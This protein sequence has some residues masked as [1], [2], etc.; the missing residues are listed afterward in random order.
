[1]SFTPRFPPWSDGSSKQRFIW[2]PSGDQI[3]SR[4]P[5]EWMR[6]GVAL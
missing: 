5:D 2:L 1:M 3:D 4:N 6:F